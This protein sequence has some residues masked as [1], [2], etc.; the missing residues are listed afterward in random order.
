MNVLR[1]LSPIV[2]ASFLT[3]SLGACVT[4]GSK[5][6]CPKKEMCKKSMG[7]DGKGRMCGHSKDEMKDKKMSTEEKEAKD[8]NELTQ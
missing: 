3:L 7:K 6:G 5:C 8:T 1:F 2:A 4:S